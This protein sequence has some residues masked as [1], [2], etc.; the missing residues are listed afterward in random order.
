MSQRYALVDASGVAQNV[1]LWD[2]ASHYTPPAGLTAVPEA[3]APAYA[4]APSHPTVVDRV[5]FWGRFTAAEQLAIST[6]AETDAQTNDW[7]VTAQ[8]HDSIDL[9]DPLTKQGLDYLVSKALI[10]AARETAILTP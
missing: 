8:V 4:P 2:G 1:I 10:T 3:Q 9:T 6:A 7:L 5:A